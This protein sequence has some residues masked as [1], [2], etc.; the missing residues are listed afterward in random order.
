[1]AHTNTQETDDVIR[2]LAD[3]VAGA[4]GS[5][6]AEEADQLRKWQM[7]ESLSARDA[8]KTTL[9][10]VAAESSVQTPMVVHSG[11][12]KNGRRA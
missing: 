3:E 8:A 6:T 9:G 1:M 7:E 2:Q 11:Y 10:H 12:D 4:N 5:L